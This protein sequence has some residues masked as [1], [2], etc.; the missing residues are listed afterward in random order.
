MRLTL[1][2]AILALLLSACASNVETQVTRF[3]EG[4]LPGGETFTVEPAASEMNGPEFRNYASLI[5]EQ[6]QWFGY[7]PVAEDPDLRVIVD[8]GVSEGRTRVESYGSY[9]HP[10]YGYHV[11]TLHPFHHSVVHPY[12]FGGFYGPEIRSETVYT[13]RLQL[14]IIDTDTDE[15]V[16]EGRALSE[17]P[18]GELAEIMP[19]LVESMFRNFPGESGATKVVEIETEGGRR[20]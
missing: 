17:G 10:F 9:G 18:N 1:L 6:M 11:G 20:Y 12:H 3:H 19:Y 7:R 14:R 13:R 15:V 4:A 8:Y 5:R 2:F 16:F